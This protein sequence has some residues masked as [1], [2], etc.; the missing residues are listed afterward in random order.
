M[1]GCPGRLMYEPKRC[2]RFG[3]KA[4]ATEPTRVA[5]PASEFRSARGLVINFLKSTYKGPPGPSG[6]RKCFDGSVWFTRP[7]KYLARLLESAWPGGTA[8]RAATFS[9][10][11]CNP[12]LSQ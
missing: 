2:V 3:R 12:A 6:G 1:F 8:L 11:F 7:V 5:K 9:V 4:G 10:Q